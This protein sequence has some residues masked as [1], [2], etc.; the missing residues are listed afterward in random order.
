M[1]RIKGLWYILVGSDLPDE[2]IKNQK[3]MD[4]GFQAANPTTD[5]RGG[6]I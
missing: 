3:W 1:K 2:Q 4:F 5:F 6:G